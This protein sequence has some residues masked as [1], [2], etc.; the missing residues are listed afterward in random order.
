[1]VV[2]ALG[3]GISNAAVFKLVPQ[4]VPQAVGGASGWVGGLGAFGGFTLPPLLGSIVASQG[5]AGYASGFWIFAGLAI[6]SLG[7]AALLARVHAS[8]QKARVESGA[9]GGSHAGR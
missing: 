1:V 7:L 5:Q 3:M 6:A 9:L 2:L 8:E 4:E